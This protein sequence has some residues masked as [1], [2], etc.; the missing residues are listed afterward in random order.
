MTPTRAVTVSA[1][2][3]VAWK[4]MAMAIA[5]SFFDTDLPSISDRDAR[6]FASI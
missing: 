5:T 2:E 1:A 4:A 3:P 6:E